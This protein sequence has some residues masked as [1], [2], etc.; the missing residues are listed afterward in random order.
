V[1]ATPTTVEIF[2][3][4]Q[5]VTSHLRGRGRGQAF[6]Q[7]EHRPKHPSGD[8]LLLLALRLFLL[9][10]ICESNASHRQLNRGNGISRAVRAAS[11]Q[12][13]KSKICGTTRGVT[14]TL[15]VE[16]NSCGTWTAWNSE[17]QNCI[18]LLCHCDL[19]LLNKSVE[20]RAETAPVGYF[21]VN[22]YIVAL[23][24]SPGLN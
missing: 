9:T 24:S 7:K 13:D 15:P 20:L 3:Q 8:F 14:P 12:I 17:K 11:R 10:R 5:R 18:C 22:K 21:S 19:S 1:R 23:E 2:H 6:T 16:F 4:G